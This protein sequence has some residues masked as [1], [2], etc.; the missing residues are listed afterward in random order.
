M[1]CGFRVSS[2]LKLLRALKCVVLLSFKKLKA[3]CGYI[4][5][6]CTGLGG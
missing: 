4:A 1:G 3:L 5:K 2:L 6:E